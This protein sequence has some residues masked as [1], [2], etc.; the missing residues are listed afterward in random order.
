MGCSHGTSG[1]AAASCPAGSLPGSLRPDGSGRR[2]R[3][4]SARRQAFVAIR[5]NQVRS[6]ER[7]SKPP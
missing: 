1:R 6:D 4:S 3:V 5:Y 2:L 7:P